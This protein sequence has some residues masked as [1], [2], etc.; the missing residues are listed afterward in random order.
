MGRTVK[1]ELVW[2]DKASAAI[3]KVESVWDAKEIAD[4]AAALKLLAAKQKWSQQEKARL[5][6]LEVRATV[7]MGELLRESDVRRGRPKK[8]SPGEHFPAQA[9]LCDLGVDR[10]QSHRAQKIAALSKRDRE[11]YIREAVKS[12]DGPTVGGLLKVAKKRDREKKR[13]ANAPF[14]GTN[15]VDDIYKLVE[16]GV[17]FGTIY[18]D[19]PWQYGNQAT[20]SATDTVYA[21][22]SMDE[23]KALPVEA[24]AAPDAHLHL[25]VTVGF[26]KEGIA[27]LEAWGF[28][29]KSNF[30]W[31]KPQ[32]GIGNYW[33]LSHEHLLLGVR[34]DATRFGD[35]SLK[36]WLESERTRHS[37][38]PEEVRD[39]IEKA[40]P[41]PYL[42]LFGR[43]K[44]QGWTVW[45]NEIGR[46]TPIEEKE[47]ESK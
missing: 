1:N 6:E 27:L 40:S 35:R 8:G 36:S 17:K 26:L 37:A 46:L 16:V 22:M 42:E 23:L 5:A 18:A 33:R 20:R 14:S 4:K 9:T 39:D 44:I 24:L 38:K 41:G 12:G 3:A 10:K 11:T 13:M 45:G 31:V 29:Y 30:A 32:L 21:T 25:W 2:L 15:T 19:P 7:R 47:A 34:G 28:T 43:K